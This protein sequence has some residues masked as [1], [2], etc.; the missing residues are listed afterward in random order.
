MLLQSGFETFSC[1]YRA[2]QDNFASVCMLRHENLIV[3]QFVG[4]PL[5]VTF[6]RDYREINWHR[7][8]ILAKKYPIWRLS[9]RSQGID[10]TDEWRLHQQ[11]FRSL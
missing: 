5:V 1:P 9:G 11:K 3:C 6:S 8:Y 10:P 4:V 2:I 7:P